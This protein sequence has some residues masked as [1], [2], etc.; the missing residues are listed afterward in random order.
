MKTFSTI[1][2]ERYILYFTYGYKYTNISL[3]IININAIEV[4]YEKIKVI[5]INY[6]LTKNI[7]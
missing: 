3:K 7:Y 1:K 2:F 4:K 6:I 5:I